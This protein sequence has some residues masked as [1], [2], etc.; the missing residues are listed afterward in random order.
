MPQ[1][2]PF[3]NL[4]GNGKDPFRF[5]AP[6]PVHPVDRSLNV[7]F[8]QPVFHTVGNNRTNGIRIA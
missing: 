1:T 7:G 8:D 5:V 6:D 2:D 4:L 3:T